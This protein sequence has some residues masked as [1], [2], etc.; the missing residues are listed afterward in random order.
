[1]QASILAVESSVDKLGNEL[2][3]EGYNEGVGYDRDPPQSLH[4]VKPGIY[5]AVSE[6]IM[7]GNSNK[8]S[9]SYH[10]PMLWTFS[11]IGLLKNKS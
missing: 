11:A 4:D 2:A 3:G 9:L 8:K 1:M 7:G 5:L 10:T 6:E